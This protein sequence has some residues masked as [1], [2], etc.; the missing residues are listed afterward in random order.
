MDITKY[1]SSKFKSQIKGMVMN[2]E[3]LRKNSDNPVD[4]T[5]ESFIKKKENVS[6]TA[7][8]DDL[9]IDPSIDTIENIFTLPDES[10][11]WLVPEIFREA[12]RLG[13]RKA[14]I[15]TSVVAAEQVSK[16]LS[17][18]IPHLNMS[19][20]VPK[21]IGEGE[22]IAKGNISFGQKTL[23]L[24][25]LGRG[26]T[27]PYEVTN[28]VSI[29]VVSIFL[30]DFGVKL[31]HAI[32]GL[33]IDTLI[34]GEQADGS[35]SA[36]VIG[37]TTPST[38]TY[39]DILRI[40]VRMSRIGR[41]PNIMIGGEAAALETLDLDEFKTNQ[42]GGKAAAFVPSNSTLKLKT[43]IPASTDYFIH[44]SMP[45]DQQLII[46][47]SA[48]VIKYNAQPLLVESEKI[49]SNQTESTYATLT[50]GFGIA[51]RDGRVLLDNTVDFDTTGGFPDY[52]DVDAL[53]DVTIE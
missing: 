42:V 1:N 11:R 51:F 31:G 13:L 18:T 49:V 23:K 34:N 46:D 2:C 43:P 36:P 10:V 41:L 22:T 27:I 6:M 53:E 24:R 45:E 20:A 39:A 29:N 40:W 5:F 9:G 37:I 4:I 16:Q 32:D 52:M 15:W 21:Y 12:L 48:A 50:T 44:G 30:Q 25:K 17:L 38:L 14:P 28:Y 33:M 47:P 26:I 3:A 19:D 35:E 7:L 8:F